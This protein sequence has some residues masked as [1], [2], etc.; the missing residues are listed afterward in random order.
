MPNFWFWSN[1]C[2]LFSFFGTLW[3][4]LLPSWH[5]FNWLLLV[6]LKYRSQSHQCCSAH[7]AYLVDLF[8][9]VSV[10]IHSHT[11]STE[12]A[13]SETVVRAYV[14]ILSLA[15]SSRNHPAS[16]SNSCNLYVPGYPYFILCQNYWGL[17]N[18]SRLSVVVILSLVQ[19]RISIDT[20][21]G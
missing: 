18:I 4:L 20:L 3:I 14:L 15:A 19:S 6:L 13:T 1:E 17:W 21:T 12:A 9:L 2:N 16:F 7:K 11:H 8:L 5:T 10:F